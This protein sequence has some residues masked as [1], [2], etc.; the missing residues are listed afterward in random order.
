[1]LG[2]QTVATSIAVH[3]PFMTPLGR[4]W[5]LFVWGYA[6]AW[7]LVNDVRSCSHIRSSIR[8]SRRCSPGSRMKVGRLEFLCRPLYDDYG[9]VIRKVSST[10]SSAA[11]NS[12]S[13]V[14]SGEQLRHFSRVFSIPSM[15]S[16]S[17][18]CAPH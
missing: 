4:G 10:K 8:S 3:G 13:R 9:G 11:S 2:T 18:S 12:A 5:A 6:L 7:A 1:M 14:S 17:A 15:S 16:N